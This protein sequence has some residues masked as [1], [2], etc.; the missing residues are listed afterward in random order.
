MSE[1][2]ALVK[3]E[4][5]GKEFGD[6]QDLLY[7]A[8]LHKVLVVLQGIDTSGKDGSIRNILRYGNAQSVRVASFKVPTDIEQG[9]D[10]LW[11]VHSQVPGSGGM[12]IFNR[13][14]YEDVLVV[15]V[16]ELVKKDVW[17]ARY[18]HINAFEKLLAD[19]GTVILKFFLHI[20]KDE[21]ER[22]L[23]DREANPDKAFK[24][25]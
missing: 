6:L 7:A 21:Q 5:L 13:S 14:H 11:R 8:G 10:F 19:S 12:T 23:L 20:S 16:H 9:H 24:L 15:R 17:K 3:R 18:D 2:E 4:K 22:R 1:A 25:M